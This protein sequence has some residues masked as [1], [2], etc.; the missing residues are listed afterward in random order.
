MHASAHSV[1]EWKVRNTFVELVEDDISEH[2][3]GALQRSQSDPML[4]NSSEQSDSRDWVASIAASPSQRSFEKFADDQDASELS[5]FNL[6][7]SLFVHQT[8]LDLCDAGNDIR[9][10]LITNFAGVN[11]TQY[12]P[13]NPQDNKFLSLGSSRHLVGDCKPCDFLRRRKCHKGV[14]CLYCHFPH[15]EPMKK[16][17][18]KKLR[19]QMKTR[20][21]ATEELY[22]KPDV[23]DSTPEAASYKRL[24]P[25]TRISL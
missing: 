19:L 11:M 18:S 8:V 2:S 12:V 20:L 7:E 25:G 5:E 16:R 1:H 15:N 21:Q 9:D 6:D 14:V 24:A 22:P 4:S 3:S 10:V 13:R 17:L 23:S